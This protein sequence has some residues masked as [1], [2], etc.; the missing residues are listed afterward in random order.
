MLSHIPQLGNVGYNVEPIVAEGFVLL[1]RGENPSVVL[2][3]VHQMVE[4]LND[5]ILPKGMRIE[6]FY[7]RTRLVGETLGTSEDAAQK[8]VSRA[9]DRLREY[10]LQNKIATATGGLAS[11]LSAH[12]VE[13]APSGLSTTIAGHSLAAAAAASV[14]TSLTTAKVIAMTTTQ[15][16]AAG[17]IILG[18]AATLFIRVPESGLSVILALFAGFFLYIGASD[19]LPESHHS[20]PKALTTVLTLL[21]AL[22]LYGAIQIAG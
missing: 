20:H 5:H 4:D 18:A 17:I 9:L 15:K 12:A 14:S 19:L 10:F 7:D 13:A 16:I 22:V 8:R 21:G 2:D 3:G 6:P 11:V 1:R